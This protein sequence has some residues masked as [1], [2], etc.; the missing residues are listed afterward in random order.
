MMKKFTCPTCNAGCGLLIEV[1]DNQVISVKPDRTHPLSKGSC[2]PKG[3]S[4]GELTKDKVRVLRPL[5]R[6]ENDFQKISWKQALHEIAEK[7]RR[8]RNT[9]TPN[10]IAYYMGTNSLH[11]YA[12]S[13]FVTS[14]MKAIGS[15]YLYNAGSVDNNNKFVAQYLLYGNSILMPIPD[16]PNT[17]LFIIIGSN[18]VVTKLSLVI[19]QDVRKRLREIIERGGEIY[20]IDPR[21]NKTAKLFANDEEHYIPIVP[22][23]DCFLLLSMINV[24]LNE[25]LEDK[26]FLK[27]YVVN[28]DQL[29]ELVRDFTPKRVEKICKIPEEK[30]V[31]LTHKFVNTK[32]AVIYGRLGTCL[33]TFC[34]LNAWVIEVLNILAGKLDRKGGALFGKNIVNVAQIGKLIGLGSIN[35]NRSRIGKYP[36]VMGAFPLGTLAREILAGNIRA[37]FISGGNPALSSPNSNEF[38]KALRKLDLCVILDFYIN[39]T[40]SIAA[41]YILPVKT[42]LEQSNYFVFD[43]NYQI[44]PHLEY[45]EA[46]IKADKY[47]PKAEWEILLSLIRL[48]KLTAFGNKFLDIIPKFYQFI[49]KEFDPEIILKIL[50]YLGQILQKRIPFL[51]SHAVTFKKIKKKGIILLGNNESGVLEKYLQTKNRKMHILSLPIIEQINLCKKEFNERL[52]NEPKYKLLENEF[53]MIGGRHLKTMNSWMHNLQNLWPNK[54]EPK[55]WINEQ[56]AN[57]LGLNSTD[58]VKI[59]NDFGSITVPILITENIM[60]KV[61]FYPHG[62]GHKNPHLSFANQHPGANI[63][64]LTNS[65]ALEK[66]SGMP[67]MNGYKVRLSKL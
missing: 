41:D 50:L 59:E 28:Y 23:T 31:R 12:H 56:D 11:H 4:L 52:T 3:L 54:W 39:E 37:L 20:V 58:Y 18:P 60:P 43:L 53:L 40:A 16:L 15:K 25:D 29:K 55:L 47:G 49:H 44:F 32:R 7:L 67:L 9:Y 66:L 65:W 62:W 21:K 8:I 63:N 36:D 5:K 42:P 17:D 34:T 61:L 26:I 10:S 38:S 46:P 2:C 24:I 57:R 6:V 51:S 35:Q 45:I 64:K 22:N 30:I 13:I 33:S 27:K 1:K 48:M 19:C 14:F